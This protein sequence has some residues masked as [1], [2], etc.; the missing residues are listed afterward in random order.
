MK[1]IYLL[2]IELKN[3]LKKEVGARGKV[4]FKA[5]RYIYVGSAQNGVE[6]RVKRHVSDEKKKHWHIDYFLEEASVKDTLVYNEG[7]EGECRTAAL[8]KE[9]FE[10]IEDFGC[11]DCSCDS[12]LFYSQRGVGPLIGSIRKI[13]GREDI[14]LEDIVQQ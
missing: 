13:K 12:H 1:G 11:S 6:S 14:G 3:A 2:M 5:G 4:E 10:Y 7:K 8:L 9:E